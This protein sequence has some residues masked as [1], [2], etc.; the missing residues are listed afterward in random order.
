[1]QN[2]MIKIDSIKD[3]IARDTWPSTGKDGKT[4][5]HEI[6]VGRPFQIP[7]DKHHNWV[8]PVMIEKFTSGI[9][10][11]Y[12]VGPV[13]ALMNAMTIVKAFSD[14]IHKAGE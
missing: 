12:G 9:V 14:K 8:C 5:T 3:V 2:K 11:A 10:T 13:D 4:I 1:M 6:I 7:N